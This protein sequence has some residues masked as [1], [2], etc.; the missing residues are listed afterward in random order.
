M[1]RCACL[2][3]GLLLIL[4]CG[5]SS[6]SVVGNWVMTAPFGVLDVNFQQDGN[7]AG[8][9]TAPGGVFQAKGTYRLVKEGLELDPPTLTDASGQTSVPPGGLMRLKMTWKSQDTVELFNGEDTFSM[10]RKPAK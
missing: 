10:V 5:K 4:G 8:T 1:R 3:L 6:Q 2:L 9:L 7:Y